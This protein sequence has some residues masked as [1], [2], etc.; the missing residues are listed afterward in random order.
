MSQSAEEQQ[1]RGP[2]GARSS[3]DALRALQL[4]YSETEALFH[5]SNDFM[6]QLY[7]PGDLSLSKRAV[8]LLLLQA[9]PQTVP[10]IARRKQVSRQYI[11]KV[12]N[13]LIEASY[14]TLAKNE[15][16]KRS[17]LAHLTE[18]GK[19]YLIERLQHEVQMVRE[20]VIPFPP[21]RLQETAH[22]LRAIRE[23]Q[24]DELQHL[25]QKYGPPS[26]RPESD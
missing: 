18:Q 9:G 2:E 7:G 4:V 13:Q 16:H 12:V 24:R 1:G 19:A 17:S 26:A 11:Q 3:E 15:A 21:D 5:Q 6:A 14:V 23:W 25:M 10:Q 20:M 22:M 8:L